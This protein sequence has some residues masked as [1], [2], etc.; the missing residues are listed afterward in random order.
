VLIVSADRRD[1]DLDK[2]W[3]T[4]FAALN[5][6]SED[7]QTIEQNSLNRLMYL[8]LLEFCELLFNSYF[9]VYVIQADA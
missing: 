6:S 8:R 3:T 9:G 1:S 2:S 7:T 5:G 4:W